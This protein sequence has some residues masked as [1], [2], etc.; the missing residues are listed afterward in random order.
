MGHRILGLL[1]ISSEG[2][3]FEKEWLVGDVP[4]RRSEGV[5]TAPRPY[6]LHYLPPLDNATIFC[7]CAPQSPGPPQTLP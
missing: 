3:L 2:K 7:A 1:P 5:G 4:R 6:Y